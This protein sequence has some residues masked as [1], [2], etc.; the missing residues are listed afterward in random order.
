MKRFAVFLG[1]ALLALPSVSEAARKTNIR[2]GGF[3]FLFADHNKL[4]NPGQISIAHGAAVE[5]NYVRQN[6]LDVEA[7]TPSFVYGN[8][9]FGFGLGA[10]RA[11]NDLTDGSSASDVAAVAMGIAMLK[12]R[13]TFGASYARYLSGGA[14]NDGVLLGSL[15]INAPKR[16]GPVFGVGYTTVLGGGGLQGLIAGLGYSFNTNSAMEL[17]FELNDLSNTDNWSG[18]FDL[19]LGNNWFYFGTEVLHSNLSGN[20]TAAARLGFIIGRY[21]DLSFQASQVLMSGGS[22]S[23]GATLRT[24]F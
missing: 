21:I 22:A 15:T 14:T 16:R 7:I 17:N 3:G 24:S 23:Y 13:L 2:R 5:A 11:G 8:G 20:Q 19:T 9:R 6:G 10:T 1:I 12:S 4:N 18:S